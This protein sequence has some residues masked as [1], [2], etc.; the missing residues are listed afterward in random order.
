MVI[1]GVPIVECDHQVVWQLVMRDQVNL[2]SLRLMRIVRDGKLT[3]IEPRHIIYCQHVCVIDL[4][5][6][7]KLGL[8][9]LYT[10]YGKIL[11]HIE[12]AAIVL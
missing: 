11:V 10:D 3:K 8:Q 1:S 4:E 12:G 9:L 5:M 7:G 2:E 6:H